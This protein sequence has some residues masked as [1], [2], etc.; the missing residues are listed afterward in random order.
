MEEKELR[1]LSDCEILINKYY[2]EIKSYMKQVDLFDKDFLSKKEFF[3]RMKNQKD[4]FYKEIDGILEKNANLNSDFQGHI[5]KAKDHHKLLDK[6]ISHQGHISVDVKNCL[7][8][9][10]FLRNKNGELSHRIDSLSMRMP[11]RDKIQQDFND[12]KMKFSSVYEDLQRQIDILR[13]VI[14]QQDADLRMLHG[15][16]SNEKDVSIKRQSDND[17]ILSQ[18]KNQINEVKSIH[19]S[20]KDDIIKYINNLPKPTEVELPNFD[21]MS[22]KIKKSVMDKAE[23]DSNKFLK[24]L[25]ISL[26]NE[27][28]IKVIN[29][30]LNSI[31]AVLEKNKFS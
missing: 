5:R 23:E 20:D 2:Q 24:A 26:L 10:D 27:I 12:M 31:L 14:S 3:E 13:N 29:K 15:K 18:L 4:F 7:S 30:K 22:E 6:T 21:D 11:N 25:D 28:E 17:S 9:I 19:K 8:Y 1:R 16:I